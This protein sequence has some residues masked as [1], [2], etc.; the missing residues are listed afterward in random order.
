MRL[1]HFGSCVW[2]ILVMRFPHLGH[3]FPRIWVM[4]LAH[5]GPL[6]RRV[7]HTVVQTQKNTEKQNKYSSL[8][9]F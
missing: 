8:L 7:Q 1:V 5:F 6:E 2:R 9:N 4:R 3:A